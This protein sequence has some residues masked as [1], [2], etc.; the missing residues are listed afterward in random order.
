WLYWA[1]AFAGFA[2]G[3]KY[4]AVLPAAIVLALVL[5]EKRDGRPL[6]NALVFLAFSS[7][8]FAP[9]LLKNYLFLHNPVAPWGTGWFSRSSVSPAV[10]AQYF[11]H[12]ASHGTAVKSLADLVSLP[13]DL[14]AFGFRF[15]GG[16][17]IPGPLFLLFI[18]A[19]FFGLKIDKISKV[20]LLVA[21]L[22]GAGWMASGK[23]LRFIVPVLPLLC[24][25]AARGFTWLA[26]QRWLKYVAYPV[27]IA[28][29]AHNLLLF[30]WTMTPVDPYRPVLCGESRDSYLARKVSYYPALR[31]AVNLLP[32][33]SRVLFWGETRTYYCTADRVAPSVFDA[34]PLVRRA[35][36]SASHQ[37]FASALKE[38]GITH[39]L[40]NPGEVQRLDMESRLS[41]AG[42]DRWAQF[43]RS[44]ARETYRDRYCQVYEII[45]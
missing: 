32:S 28:G 33:G 35:N 10:A 3:V 7:A 25:F 9:W 4:T 6:R 24:I 19:L 36:S 12:I 18:P 45:Y 1:G 5:F 38:D 39:V 37:E 27:L 44:N 15:G 29:L 14:T 17:D 40:V 22:F 31:N 20:L 21:V 16:F 23:V 34:H 8:A 13:W 41:A 11:Q 2:C 43:L 26:G 42:K 30:H